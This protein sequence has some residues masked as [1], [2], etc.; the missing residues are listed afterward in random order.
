MKKNKYSKIYRAAAKFCDG[1][2]LRVAC[3]SIEY[4]SA[5]FFHSDKAVHKFERLFMPVFEYPRHAWL[6]D[7]TLTED[8]Q[9]NRRVLALLLMSEIAKETES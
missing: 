9:K 5:S 1:S 6:D 3:N 4:V 2:K 8:E 7:E